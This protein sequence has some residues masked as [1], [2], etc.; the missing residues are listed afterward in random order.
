MHSTPDDPLRK[1]AVLLRSMDSNSSN[2]ILARMSADEAGALR[3][4][5]RSLGEVDDDE[6]EDA[7][8]AFR[9][10]PNFASITEGHG[11]RDDNG[12]ELSLSGWNRTEPTYKPGP[13]PRSDRQPTLFQD[14]A[15][16]EPEAIARYLAGEQPQTVAV[17]LFYLSPGVAAQ[18]LDQLPQSLRLPVL[19]RLADLD[20]PGAD[21]L[22][23]LAEGLKRWIASHRKSSGLREE[24]R[25]L[26]AA[27]LQHTSE[28]GRRGLAK[29]ISSEPRDWWPEEV[30]GVADERF[31][32][33]PQPKQEESAAP[34]I[35]API[36]FE[37]LASLTPYELVRVLRGS[38]PAVVVLALVGAEEALVQKIERQLTRRQVATLRSKIAAIGPTRLRDVE[39]AQLTLAMIASRLAEQRLI[40]RP[41][42]MAA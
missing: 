20:D 32:D 33:A 17:V 4:A 22:Q 18:V 24:R 30:A 26:I 15:D 31:D 7:A 25:Q 41:G 11:S 39:A 38:P 12:V 9:S 19:D 42:R 1:A 35:P 6:R 16:A 8:E 10:Q 40:S 5:M 34:A 28:D 14:L 21:N 27:I 23:V 3:R 37:E 36:R 13:S 29:S 2:A